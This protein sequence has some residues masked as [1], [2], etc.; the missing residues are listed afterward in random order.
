MHDLYRRPKVAELDWREVNLDKLL[1][2]ESNQDFCLSSPV[3]C[4]TNNIDGSNI[5]SH[6]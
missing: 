3:Q 5:Y 2:L 6:S 4:L 1:I